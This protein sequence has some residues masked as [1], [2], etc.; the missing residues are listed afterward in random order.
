MYWQEETPQ[1]APVM[2]HDVVDI[3]FRIDCRAL[4]LDHAHA[5]SQA[6][7]AELLWFM[8]EE[9]AGL[10]LIHGAAS[11]NGWMRPE[12]PDT[13]LLHLS[14]RTRL[15]LR[16]PAHRVAEAQ[17]LTGKTLDINGHPLRIEKGIPR[18]LMPADT[19]FS[20]HVVAGEADNE[21]L[22]LEDV[23]AQLRATGIAVRKILC[24][25]PHAISTPKEKLFTRSVMVADL[26]PQES[27][28]LQK[29]GLGA[30]RKIGCGLFIPHKGIAPVRKQARR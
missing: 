10:H 16:L 29:Q 22:F 5:L 24:G 9:A 4:P 21:A 15:T 2:A 30:G 18:P 17:A 3:A 27:I 6:L 23:A 7:H 14:R 19:L 1:D 28:T 25:K 8:Q 11:G 20:R 13:E 26:T 12:D